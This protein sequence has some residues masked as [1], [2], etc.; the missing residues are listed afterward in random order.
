[1]NERGKASLLSM[2]GLSKKAGHAI[3]G[4]DM[5][6]DAVRRGKICLVLAA[7]GVSDN[8]KKKLND[9]CAYYGVKLIFI[10]ALP[11]ELGH[12]VGKSG[13]VA[14]VGIDDAGF[15]ASIESKLN[16]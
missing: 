1:M 12:A 9:K 6:C 11:D 16:L 5:V 15:A 4:T 7:E 8:T 10:P 3:C 13:A 14:A 2:I